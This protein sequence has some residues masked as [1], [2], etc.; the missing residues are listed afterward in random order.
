MCVGRIKHSA[1][2]LS[3][4]YGSDLSSASYNKSTESFLMG[5][6]VKCFESPALEE[7]EGWE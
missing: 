5:P 3:I 4:A 7:L 2:P 1:M 6:R